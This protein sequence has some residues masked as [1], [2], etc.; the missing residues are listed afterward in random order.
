MRSCA[1]HR[2]LEWDR[3]T[4]IESIKSTCPNCR[5]QPTAKKYL[6]QQPT[7]SA[8]CMTLRHRHF[9]RSSL[10]EIAGVEEGK[11][12]ES[13][14]KKEA[15]EEEEHAISHENGSHSSLVLVLLQLCP[16][17]RQRFSHTCPV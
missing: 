5:N 10:I 2:A 13:I 6:S 12:E 15:D 16:A 17:D 9:R 7:G 3:A 11:A 14:E 4:A 8:W 1:I